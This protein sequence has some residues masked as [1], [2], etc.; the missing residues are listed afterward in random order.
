MFFFCYRK[1]KMSFF[2]PIYEIN[3]EHEAR[4][5]RQSLRQKS[6]IFPPDQMMMMSDR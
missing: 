1:A 6:W 4:L 2:A 5:E 3:L